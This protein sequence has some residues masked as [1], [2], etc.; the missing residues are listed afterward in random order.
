V[1][2]ARK[3]IPVLDAVFQVGEHDRE[4]AG[5]LLAGAIAFRL[6]LWLVPFALVAVTV[7]GALVADA[8]MSLGELAR[9]FGVVGVMAKYVGDASAQS[10]TTLV[11]VLVLSLYALFIASRSALRALRLAHLLAW[12]MPIVRFVRSTGTALWFALGA[13]ALIGA[14]GLVN[15]WRVAHPG[16]GLLLLL[17][18]MVVDGAAWLAASW[19]LPHPRDVPLRGL[20]P[21]A[22]LFAAGLE[23]LR[24][25]TVLWYAARIEH[26][27]ELY[28]GLG[29]AV[30][31]LAWLYL[32]G[33]LAISSAVVNAS[34]WRRS[35]PAPRDRPGA[36]APGVGFGRHGG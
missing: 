12:E 29:A 4:V 28:G 7:L 20:V 34:L 35:H 25:V 36:A 30:A 5:G 19:Y 3:R 14:G 26:S 16:P 2:A 22:V 18:L 17:A 6:F 9:R 11:I 31:L 21:G 23:A 27:S 15:S 13:M 10:N 32:L 8:D 33:R 1:V 24:L